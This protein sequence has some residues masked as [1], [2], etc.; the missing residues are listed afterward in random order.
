[1]SPVCASARSRLMPDVTAKAHSRKTI[2]R[3]ENG[4]N[5]VT[6]AVSGSFPVG[7]L[8]HFP[9]FHMPGAP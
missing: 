9:H 2:H 6:G 8:Q 1:M 4:V 5:A 7:L 3:R